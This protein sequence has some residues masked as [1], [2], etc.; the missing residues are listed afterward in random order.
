MRRIKFIAKTVSSIFVIGNYI[1][2][3]FVGKLVLADEN[4]KRRFFLKHVNNHCKILLKLMGIELMI[5][6][7]EQLRRGKNYM[8]LGNHMSYLDPLILAAI[9]PACFV[10]SMEIRETP[11]LG[12][13]TELGGC[14]F[15]ERRDKKNI[16]NEIGNITRGLREGFHVVI[17]PEATSTDGTKVLPFKRSLLNASI[18]AQKDILP[19]V[20]QYEA[21]DG[22]PVTA[23]N[24]DTLCWYG[25]MTF[26]PHFLQ[27][28]KKN[29]IRI[30]VKFL[31]EIPVSN[32][33][34]RDELVEI[35][36][37]KI[38]AQYRPIKEEE[39]I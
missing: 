2:F 21:I 32:D 6:N 36:Y 33:S 13:L 12:L 10:T 24:R 34:T 14:L 26:A 15:V 20:I 23:K 5:E 1:V 9:E 18:D 19:I 38:S 39:K 22:E 16:G 4:S 30:R 8:M 7:Q 31:D 27:L 3:A 35:A 29:R 37:E 17:F 11:V 28:M 25:D